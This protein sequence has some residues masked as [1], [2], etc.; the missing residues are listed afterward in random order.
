[1]I[2]EMRSP[3][4]IQGEGRIPGRVNSPSGAIDRR[5]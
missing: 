5:E 3:I 2:H 4:N 1:V